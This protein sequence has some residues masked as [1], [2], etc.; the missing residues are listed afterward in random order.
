LPR[1]Y[2]LT[3]RRPYL[4]PIKMTTITTLQLNRVSLICSNSLNS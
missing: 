2:R 1:P 3:I 4:F